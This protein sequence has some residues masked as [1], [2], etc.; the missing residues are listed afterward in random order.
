MT[1]ISDIERD[2]SNN[3]N[4]DKTKVEFE[5]KELEGLPEP[6]LKKLEKV[7]EKEG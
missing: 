1:K 7:P 4:N 5:E 3:I 6:V 2:S